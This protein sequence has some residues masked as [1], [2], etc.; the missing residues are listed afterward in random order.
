MKN[1]SFEVV[2]AQLPRV[3]NDTTNHS[4]AV[5]RFEGIVRADTFGER[6]VTG[7][8]YQAHPELTIKTGLGILDGVSQEYGLERASCLHR[9]G[10]VMPGEASILVECA[11][12][13]RL[14]AFEAC[15]TIMDRIKAE[16][17]IWKRELYS[18]GS[19]EWS[20]GENLST[21]NA[22]F[23]RQMLL[24]EVGETGQGTLLGSTITIVGAGG[25]G[26][27]ISRLL[28]GAG[29]GKLRILDPDLVSEPDLHRQIMYDRRDLKRH[30]ATRLCQ[31]LRLLDPRITLKA[32]C[33]EINSSNAAEL[34]ANSDLVIDAVDTFAGK[35]A[36]NDACL[37]LGI[38]F[39]HA[40]L[41]QWQGEIMF[42]EPGHPC[43]RC[44]WREE[45]QDGC[46]GTCQDSG[47]IGTLPNLIGALV[48][49][50]AIKKLLKISDGLGPGT[51]LL[52][53]GHQLTI[54]KV[55]VGCYRNCPV[56]NPNAG[57]L[58]KALP[59]QDDI[60]IEVHSLADL[61]PYRIL[62]IRDASEKPS[63]ITT[64]FEFEALTVEV[65]NELAH[66]SR[67]VL[68]VCSRGWKSA[69]KAKQLRAAIG[70]KVYSLK[71][72]YRTLK[73]LK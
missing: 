19:S 31:K 28:A 18:D 56:C 64:G 73:T 43:L 45:P 51:L 49:H 65:E 13:H 25:L 63:N 1:C 68:L 29:V 44:L 17:P 34:L 62:D 69:V 58:H 14:E 4:G 53:D 48:A 57:D 70:K 9:V 72:G 67:P 41:S 3:I 71:G 6:T 39:L 37:E 15:M 12:P 33:A 66:E 27:I 22:I 47:V 10:N 55:L 30:K 38:P 20:L 54:K 36:I 32:I 50:E 2:Y 42:V 40:A 24:P 35:L 8:D 61:S 59:L 21:Q 7:I 16:V 46:V 11:S 52:V 26:S 60:Q 5:V 23:Q